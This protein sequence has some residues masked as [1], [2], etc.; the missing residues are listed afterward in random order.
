LQVSAW[1]TSMKQRRR[2]IVLGAFIVIALGLVAFAA[3]W[4]LTKLNSSI[5]TMPVEGAQDVVLSA[6]ADVVLDQSVLGQ[7]GGN[8]H[9]S[10]PIL[11]Q[12][13]NDPSAVKERAILVTTWLNASLLVKDLRDQGGLPQNQMVSSTYLTRLP[14]NHKSDGWRNPYCVFS[15]N[16]KVAV[17]S[18]GEKG[19]LKCDGL[20]GTAEKL[21]VLTSVQKLERLP[22]GILFTIQTVGPLN[23]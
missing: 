17:L 8:N 19:A 23:H 6:M 13:A 12:Y 16:G 5:R 15:Y 2:H 21:T 22:N 11:D 18:G 9:Q 20:A 7:T 14:L 3:R 4:Q 1:A 10:G